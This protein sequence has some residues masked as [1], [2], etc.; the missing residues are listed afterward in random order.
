[1]RVTALLASLTALTVAS[2]ALRAQVPPAV[3]AQNRALADHMN[4]A[5]AVHLY[6]PLQEHAPY[7]GVR[8]ERDIRYGASAHER[9]D[10][11]VPMNSE[12]GAART[13]S[14]RAVL[15]LAP[16]ESDDH[17]SLRAGRL[18]D[19]VALWAARHA[20]IGITMRR[21]DDDAAWPSGPRDVAALVAYLQAHIAQSGGDPERLLF[22]GSGRGGL[23]VM[24]YLAHHEYWCCH[25]PGVAA[26]A[27][28]GAPMNLAARG[29]GKGS[30]PDVDTAHSALPG[31]DEVYL[32]VF[33]GIPQYLDFAT[34]RAATQLQ[35]E[36][37]R[38]GRC[39][40]VR[41]FAN[42]GV[43]SAVLSFDTSDESVSG[44][45]L[46]WLRQVVRL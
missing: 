6:A 14:L 41:H 20:L 32:P 11:F 13:T 9:M 21:R 29:G 3:A 44:Q 38:R 19:N 26:L 10:L 34:E 2:A 16:P 43:L 37:C 46:A 35:Q 27:L 8:V 7:R 36:L 39:P 31:L 42:H 25:G 45:L 5:A 1:M 30:L 22:I 12:P 28:L 18:Y 4:V 23:Q 15:V 17:R 33:I 24:S 40:T